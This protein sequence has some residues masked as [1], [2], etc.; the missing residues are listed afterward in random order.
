MSAY[1]CFIHTVVQPSANRI[2]AASRGINGKRKLPTGYRYR[3]AYNP[4]AS[5]V[6]AN[7]A[8][9]YTKFTSDKRQC[10]PVAPA[11]CRP[12]APAQCRPVAP[13]QKQAPNYTVNN[14]AG[15]SVAVL[16]IIFF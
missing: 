2:P 14:F 8:P 7:S 1:V 15:S 11:Q 13:V 16:A 4:A 6:P 5:S 12:V 9:C 3:Q 10:R